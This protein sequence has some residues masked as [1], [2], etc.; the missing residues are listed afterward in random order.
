MSGGRG[1]AAAMECSQWGRSG[2]GGKRGRQ[3]SG[4]DMQAAK[5]SN[6]MTETDQKKGRE[7]GNEK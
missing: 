6:T 3:R 4:K 2:R 5:K 7:R 1:G